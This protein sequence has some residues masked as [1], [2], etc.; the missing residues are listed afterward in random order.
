MNVIKTTQ[1][2]CLKKKINLTFYMVFNNKDLRKNY[3]NKIKY[4]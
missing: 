1:G 2:Q 3:E 4:L